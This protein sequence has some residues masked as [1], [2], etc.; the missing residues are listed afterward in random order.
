[1]CR[2]NNLHLYAYFMKLDEILKD[3]TNDI[4]P[5]SAVHKVHTSKLSEGNRNSSSSSEN[6]YVDAK[7][8]SKTINQC[9]L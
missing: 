4:Y 7:R 6:G 3:A 8:D 2:L 9:L 1:M 5:T